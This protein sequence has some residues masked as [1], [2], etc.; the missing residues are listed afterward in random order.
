MLDG[1]TREK[2]AELE[3]GVLETGVLDGVGV[4][5]GVGVGVLVGGGV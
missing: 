5:V 2:E 3:R 4:D 1:A